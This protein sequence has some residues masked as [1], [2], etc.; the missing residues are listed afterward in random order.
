MVMLMCHD[1]QVSSPDECQIFHPFMT[2]CIIEPALFSLIMRYYQPSC[3]DR[4]RVFVNSKRESMEM[5]EG[6]QSVSPTSNAFSGDSQIYI[7][8]PV[9]ALPGLPTYTQTDSITV[10][11]RCTASYW[12]SRAVPT[13]E[14]RGKHERLRHEQ[15]SAGSY[16]HQVSKVS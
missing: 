7:L 1:I 14:F 9:L 15:D 2:D 12:V 11:Y 4:T 13:E 6:R 10:S 5:V 16:S 8:T 3:C